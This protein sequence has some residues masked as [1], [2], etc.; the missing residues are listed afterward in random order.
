MN[1]KHQKPHNITKI[2]PVN[3]ALLQHFFSA[4]MLHSIAGD[5]L[6]S[7]PWSFKIPQFMFYQQNFTKIV[8]QDQ[9]LH[10]SWH[11]M[12]QLAKNNQTIYQ[13]LT[14]P[15]FSGEWIPKD[16]RPF[17]LPTML[18]LAALPCS[19]L[20]L[21]VVS[22][23]FIRVRK[24]VITLKLL[25]SVKS[26]EAMTLITPPS[27]IWQFPTP[28]NQVNASAHITQN[29][30]LSPTYVLVAGIIAIV[31]C[32]G[33]LMWITKFWENACKSGLILELTNGKQC[34]QLNI[35]TSPYAQLSTPFM[36]GTM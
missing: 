14:D 25:Q 29:V 20:M 19:A 26:G 15:I 5:T 11:K 16:T 33:I 13:S 8:A 34:V 12:A 27:L 17:D 21:A 10:F 30:S 28:V 9:Q 1:C 2:D 31:G 22:I 36:V 6:P 24:L 32:L 35:L 18:S 23:L 7:T 4:D 3:L